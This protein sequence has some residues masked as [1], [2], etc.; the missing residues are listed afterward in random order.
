MLELVDEFKAD[1]SLNDGIVAIARDIAAD[2]IDDR[3]VDEK[4]ATFEGTRWECEAFLDSYYGIQR[5]IVL[6]AQSKAPE[7]ESARYDDMLY[8]LDRRVYRVTVKPIAVA[9]GEPIRPENDY[10]AM[11]VKTALEMFDA[12]LDG[13]KAESVLKDAQDVLY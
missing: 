9:T 13:R 7:D 1:K 3:V 6:G 5:N 10:R 4:T 12:L 8:V 11:R 2:L